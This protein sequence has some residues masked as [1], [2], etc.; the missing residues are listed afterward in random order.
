MG[1]ITLEE[2]MEQVIS[3]QSEALWK[4][5]ATELEAWADREKVKKKE[6]LSMV[7]DSFAVDAEL[8]PALLV[9]RRLQI[10]TEFSCAGVSILDD[11]LDHS[12]YAY[13]TFH[14]SE[15]TESFVEFAANYMKHRV[16]VTYEPARKRY[17]M[18]SFFIG[19]NRSFCLLMYRCAEA[20]AERT[21]A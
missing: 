19:H 18:S 13:V 12:V 14:A 5:R 15:Q 21:G 16:L 6:K 2:D 9:L 11:P 4:R 7:L 20:F 17:D 1:N 10:P 8:Y 3:L